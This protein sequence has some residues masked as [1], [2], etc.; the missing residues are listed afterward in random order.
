MSDGF[1]GSLKYSLADVSRAGSLQTQLYAR[2][3]DFFQDYDII[4]APSITISPRARDP[5]ATRM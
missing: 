4:L 5:R 3:Q 2:W 1:T